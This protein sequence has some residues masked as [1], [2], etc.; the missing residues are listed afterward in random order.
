[1]Q[2]AKSRVFVRP[3]GHIKRNRVQTSAA[4]SHSDE[5]SFFQKIQNDEQSHYRAEFKLKSNNSAGVRRPASPNRRNKPHPVQVYHLRRLRSGL[6]C[7]VRSK[8]PKEAME[9]NV[10]GI[11]PLGSSAEAR[12][13]TKTVYKPYDIR[14]TFQGAK[15]HENT[16]KFPAI[17]I[18][19]TC[20]SQKKQECAEKFDEGV[21]D[22]H[23]LP[24]NIC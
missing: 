18:I 19:P 16:R 21:R 13:W 11:S 14:S 10:I 1:M 9:R 4:I 17:G 5:P 23:W 12:S 22:D 24:G 20:F 15:L 8:I 3:I 6:V 7:D 2:Q